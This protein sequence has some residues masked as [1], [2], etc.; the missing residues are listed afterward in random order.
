MDS[1]EFYPSLFKYLTVFIGVIVSFWALF[2]RPRV[3]KGFAI[4]LLF[5]IAII[6][7]L[8]PE[9]SAVCYRD[10]PRYLYLFLVGEDRTAI[11]DI[12]F[13]LY[14]RICRFF[15][16]GNYHL[17]FI[18]SGLIYVYGYYVF[19]RDSVDN[20]LF[21]TILFITCL[22]SAGFMNY[23]VNT[24]RSG[25]ALSVYLT[26]YGAELRGK[27]KLSYSLMFLACLVHISLL[28]PVVCHFISRIKVPLYW[29]YLFWVLMLIITIINVFEPMVS[30][31]ESMQID[32]LVNYMGDEESTYNSGFRTDFV[33]YSLLPIIAS[34]YYIF[35]KKINNPVYERLVKQY[36]LI[37]A[38]WLLF[39]RMVYTDRFA[40][41]SWFMIPF[42][43]M[44][45]LTDKRMDRRYISAVILFFIA[46]KF[47]V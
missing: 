44:V 22:L 33:L 45:P 4:I 27:Q 28:L 3:P 1:L 10:R 19:C 12:G 43:L 36:I 47:I 41:L 11:T 7:G 32:R 5:V 17:F 29:F 38:I 6:L 31:V 40:Y 16:G 25:L 2:R 15:F 9:D 24:M 13:L 8:I 30:L 21:F 46:F 23:G 37:N 42:V 39:I 18:L 20:D 14:V 35:M 34:H 26:A